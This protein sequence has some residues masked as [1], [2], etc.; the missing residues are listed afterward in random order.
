MLATHRAQHATRSPHPPISYPLSPDDALFQHNNL[1]FSP[2]SASPNP[3]SASQK[4]NR[5]RRPSIASPMSWLSRTSSSNSNTAP[6]AA[7]IKPM[8]ISEPQLAQDLE[9]KP[10]Q[11][12]RPLGSGAM[13]VRTPQEALAGSGVTVDYTSDPES[14]PE[15]VEEEDKESVYASEDEHEDQHETL[16]EEKPQELPRTVTP[17]IPPAYSPPRPTLPLSKSTPTLPLRDGSL[18]ARPTRPPPP[19]PTA[20]E[21]VVHTTVVKPTPSPPMSSYFPPVPPLPS[22]LVPPA[23]APPFECILLSSVPNN[24]I[25][26][27]KVIV[28]LETCTA[29]HRTTLST[30]T[31]RPSHLSDYLQSLFASPHDPD[32]VTPHSPTSEYSPSESTFNSIFHHHLTASGLLPGS[33]SNVH[34][35]LDRPSALYE[36]ILTFL[37]SPPN[38]IDHTTA[39]PHAVQLHTYSTARVETLVTLRDEARYLGLDELARLCTDELLTRHPHAPAHA[40]GASAGSLRSM[41]TLREEEGEP[42]PPP[43]PARD[44]V[45]S[46]GST[47]SG[48]SGTGSLRDRPRVPSKERTDVPVQSATLRGRNGT[49]L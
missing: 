43:V 9:A 10:Y 22:H 40:R 30:L 24:A 36:H 37:R 13:V 28:T 11:R 41:T 46:S 14:I 6:Y 25:D 35:F 45:A 44:S 12:H 7:A 33:A 42:Q 19:P 31:S 8:R 16:P 29:T 48:R 1:P 21:P 18:R 39:L 27:N 2:T 34:I 26:L 23:P 4:P 38:T 49:W 3:M 32:V 15:D 47:R 17:A 5:G 20:S